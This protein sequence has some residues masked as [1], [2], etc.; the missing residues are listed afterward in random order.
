MIHLTY[1]NIVF[2]FKSEAGQPKVL[3]KNPQVS[4][5]CRN[6]AKPQKMA[7]LGMQ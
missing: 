3:H 4:K 7:P 1:V 2:T 5:I 6:L